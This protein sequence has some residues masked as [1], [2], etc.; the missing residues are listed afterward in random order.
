MALMPHEP[1]PPR[2]ARCGA[3]AVGPCARCH[4]LLCADCAEL[5]TGLTRPFAV[6]RRCH[7]AGAGQGLGRRALRLVLP[8]VFVLAALVAVLWLVS[9]A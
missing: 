7:A 4:D 3:E 6:C 2:C 1:G 8:F 5:V 9:R